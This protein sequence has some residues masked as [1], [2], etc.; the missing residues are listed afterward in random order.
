MPRGMSEI[1]LPPGPMFQDRQQLAYAGRK[2]H[3]L[4]LTGSAEALV[5]RPNGWITAGRDQ[6]GDLLALQ[7][8]T[9]AEK[10]V[11]LTAAPRSLSD[12]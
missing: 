1:V 5:E 8:Q 3:F 6:R 10:L 12:V 2:R 7:G 9:P 4:R 11:A